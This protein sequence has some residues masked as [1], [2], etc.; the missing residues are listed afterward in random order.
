[1]YDD[2][3]PY[4][5]SAQRL[6]VATAENRRVDEK[7]RDVSFGKRRAWRFLRAVRVKIGRTGEAARFARRFAARRFASR[8]PFVKV[9]GVY[10]AVS[11][12]SASGDAASVRAFAG[13]SGAR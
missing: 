1:M 2:R 10:S 8:S 9:N 7:K 4:R 12:A 3:V 6:T 5:L 11:C 13:S